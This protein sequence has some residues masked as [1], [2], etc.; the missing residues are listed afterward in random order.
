MSDLL[1]LVLSCQAHRQGRQAAVRA[2]WGRRPE[3]G[4]RILYV[5]G[6]HPGDRI[7]EDRLLLSAPDGYADLAEKSYRMLEYCLRTLEFRALVK[8]DDDTYLDCA[9]L[10]AASGDFGDYA[11]N[12]PPDQPQFEPYAQGGC[13]WLSCKAVQ[14]V[15]SRPFA[16]HAAAPWFKGNSRMRKLGEKRYRESVSIEDVMIGSLLHEAGIRLRADRRFHPDLR[17][18]L[19]SRPDLISNHYVPPAW[20]HRLERMRTWPRTPFR[21]TLMSLWTRLPG[22]GAPR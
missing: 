14:A 9:R 12:P 7:E 10:A 5:E 15:V 22:G 17:P 20:M 19:Y 13:Y 11:G 3:R 4:Q 8:C 18:P 1:I 21:R 6:G 16:E 2:S